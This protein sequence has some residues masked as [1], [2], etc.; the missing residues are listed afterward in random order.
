MGAGDATVVA[1]V[2]SVVSDEDTALEKLDEVG[3]RMKAV[4]FT[5]RVGTV[6]TCTKPRRLVVGQSSRHRS[7]TAISNFAEASGFVP[8]RVYE[9]SEVE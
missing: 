5:V 9:V 6:P 4:P 8:E 2:L 7:P 3:A 1:A